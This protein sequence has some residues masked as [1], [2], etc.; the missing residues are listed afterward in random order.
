T[1]AASTP[2]AAAAAVEAS[3]DAPADAVTQLAAQL[4]A[5]AVAASAAAVAAT[6]AA[7]S[8]VGGGG[9]A[10]AAPLSA[11]EVCDLVSY[12]LAADVGGEQHVAFLGG[13]A[14]RLQDLQRRAAPLQPAQ[15]QQQGG[16]ARRDGGAG[17]E[18]EG[19]P[20]RRRRVSRKST[21]TA[22][23]AKGKSE[24]LPYLG[25]LEGLGA[26]AAGMGATALAL[27]MGCTAQAISVVR[28]AGATGTADAAVILPKRGVDEDVTEAAVVRQL[29][30]AAAAL[31]SPLASGQEQ[32]QQRDGADAGDDDEGQLTGDKLCG[33]AAAALRLQR[34]GAAPGA[35]AAAA[36]GGS[37]AVSA[38]LAALQSSPSSLQNASVDALAAVIAAAT[39]VDLS[40]GTAAAVATAAS[41]ELRD[42]DALRGFGGRDDQA[43]SS[44]SS[45]PD[46]LQPAALP[47]GLLDALLTQLAAAA[48]AEAKAKAA[49]DA[50]AG[51]SGTTPP[52]L[53]RRRQPSTPQLS[54]EQAFAVLAA[55]TAAAEAAAGSAPSTSA[56]AAATTAAEPTPDPQRVAG[57]RAASYVACRALAL[58]VRQLDS[59]SAVRLLQ[60]VAR[61]HK[62]GVRPDFPPLL[63]AL[64]ERLRVLSSTLSPAG[65][66]DVLRACTALRWRPAVLLRELVLPLLRWLQAGADAHTGGLGAGAVAALLPEDVE[67]RRNVSG[68]AG[69]GDVDDAAW[70]QGWRRRPEEGV[71]LPWTPA[72]LKEALLLLASLEFGGQVAASLV[73][74]GV[75][76]L[77]RSHGSAVG[78][79]R[80]GSG[81]GASAPGAVLSPA[82]LSLL[83]WVCVSMRYRGA[84]LLRQLL[85]LLLQVPS[86][87]VE[88]RVAAQAVWAAARL[89]AVSERLVRWAL[90]ACQGPGKLTAAAP[91]SLALLC[92]G[93]AKLGVKPPRGFIV[94][95]TTATLAQLQRFKPQELATTLFVL[96]TWRGR[97]DSANG[98]AASV[99]QHVVAT[100][101][102]YD[103]PELCTAV[104]ALQRLTSASSTDTGSTID[105]Q[106]DGTEAPAVPLNAAALAAIENRLLKILAASDP[107]V[108]LRIPD[109]HL[110]RYFSACAASAAAAPN[111]QQRHRPERLLSLY[112]TSLLRRLRTL[113][114]CPSYAPPVQQSSKFLWSVARVM[115][116][117]D[118]RDPDLLSSLELA[119]AHWQGLLQPSHLA[120]LLSDMAALGHYPQHWA[121]RGLLR[122][123]GLAL[124]VAS[125]TEAGLLLEAMAAWR[126]RMRPEATA[127]IA[128]AAAPP[129]PSEAAESRRM[130]NEEGGL[131][132]A[133][134]GEAEQG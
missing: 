67:G 109:H 59:T 85:Q 89:G 71:L 91:Q 94:A 102:L 2:A 122:R 36:D 24:R 61:S 83:L 9:A 56:A 105:S 41:E 88:V 119:A 103:G 25:L 132:D 11:G 108:G 58:T 21:G 39:D 60:L 7:A 64:H 1:S 54:Y 45:S 97:L 124:H 96:A 27:A 12:R 120:G 113:R 82:D 74:L 14:N 23:E 57:L 84:A 111:A 52:R 31:A 43:P 104:W 112:S 46:P 100:R 80:A 134:A 86:P 20:Q 44:S 48:A 50:A 118:I 68:D 73:K 75:G 130:E 53:R 117:Y 110:L 99:V 40:A 19:Q 126:D 131:E 127:A 101:S 76:A 28:G 22:A 49:A 4:A 70:R 33:L 92:W 3:D 69:G 37:D 17:S 72:E 42:T 6:T 87:Q 106:L 121:A 47:A 115:S 55:A 90:A 13:L 8:D 51:T 95:A 63:W 34:M 29:L 66:L 62:A 35:A 98:E 114:A 107:R 78:A 32:Q 10:G 79:R 93:L 26:S 128:A 5:Q 38:V 125:V 16:Q 133:V 116:M 81:G 30:E 77:L 18:E 123:V 65:S 15:Q 129:P